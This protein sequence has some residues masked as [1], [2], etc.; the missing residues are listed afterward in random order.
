MAKREGYHRVGG[1]LPERL[2]IRL[3][4]EAMTDPRAGSSA[5]RMLALILAERYNET[6]PLRKKAGRP[7]GR[8]TATR[9]STLTD[10][11]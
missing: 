7:P 6:V 11:R 1:D 9:R 10:V 3:S 8:K 5:L 2:W 4:E